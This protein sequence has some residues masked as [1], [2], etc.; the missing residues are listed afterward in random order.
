MREAAGRTPRHPQR[1]PDEIPAPTT[2]GV[3]QA[4]RQ[5][6]RAAHRE[7]SARMS[8]RHQGLIR[9]R[10]RRAPTLRVS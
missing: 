7:K 10:R 3:C 5:H 2:A 8:L 9:M 4:R 1:L 6:F